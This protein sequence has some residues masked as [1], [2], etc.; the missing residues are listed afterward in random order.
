MIEYD[1]WLE[2]TKNHEVWE[3]YNFE[4]DFNEDVFDASECRLNFYYLYV[5]QS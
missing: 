2:S 5:L 1:T 3:F 4:T